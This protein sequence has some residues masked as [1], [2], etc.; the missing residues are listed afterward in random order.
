MKFWA[1]TRSRRALQGVSMALVLS[2]SATLAL[3][4]SASA[5]S[6]NSLF[7]QLTRKKKGTTATPAATTGHTQGSGTPATTETAILNDGSAAPFI[8]PD[9]A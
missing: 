8:T 3:P 7:S 5:E 4:T 1:L 9:S 2:L 6:E